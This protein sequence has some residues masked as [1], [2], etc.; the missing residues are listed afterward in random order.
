[1]P[2]LHV[3][4]SVDCIYFMGQA[5]CSLQKSPVVGM[6]TIQWQQARVISFPWR[7]KTK[8]PI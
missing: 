3:M 7:F 4:V 2:I 5:Y 1:M 8:T 6:V